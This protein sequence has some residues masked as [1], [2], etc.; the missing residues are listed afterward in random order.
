LAEE[1]KKPEFKEEWE[2]LKQ[3]KKSLDE[4]AQN[5]KV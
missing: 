5:K 1:L 2:K 4:E 3:R